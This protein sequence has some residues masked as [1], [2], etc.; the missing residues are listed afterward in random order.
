M[1]DSIPGYSALILNAETYIHEL[2]HLLGLP[3]L[4]SGTH[5]YGPLG[6]W[7][8]M[9]YN[10]GDHG[11]ANKLL[12]GWLKPLVA[13]TGEYQV[14]LDSYSKDSD[15]MNSALLIPYSGSNLSD[16]DAFDEYLLVVFYTPG[17]LYNAHYNT[18]LSVED[19]GIVVYHVDARLN[20]SF[21]FWGNYF[22][23]DNDGTSNLFI[24]LLEA[25]GNN[26]IPSNSG[27]GYIKQTDLLTNGTFNLATNYDWIQGGDINVS[28]TIASVFNNNS[29][30]VTL[31]VSVN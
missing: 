5:S 10:V 6:G 18:T 11:P 21:S 17:G 27:S 24:N 23:V 22:R 29:D 9:D 26:S 31:T 20:N 28:I 14:T 19:A 15:G 30:A 4:Y 8:M 12:Y 16:G 3:D 1:T 2:G 7:D 25:D 13:T